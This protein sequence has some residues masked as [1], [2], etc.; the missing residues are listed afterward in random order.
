MI[1]GAA[2]AALLLGSTGTIW[3]GTKPLPQIAHAAGSAQAVGPVGTSEPTGLPESAGNSAQPP[4]AQAGPAASISKRPASPASTPALASAAATQFGSFS[5]QLG[6]FLDAAKAKS[7]TD[8]IAARGYTPIATDAADGYGRTWHYVRLG[9]FADE[10][11]ASLGSS[12]L[13]KRAGIGSVVVRLSAANA[14]P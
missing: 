6:A 7:L 14:G 4:A 13:L 12:D 9:V 3:L 5:L 8:Q 10:H 11:A 2:L 1:V